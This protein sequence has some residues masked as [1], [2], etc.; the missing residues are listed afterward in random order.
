M[1]RDRG[2]RRERIEYQ[3][4]LAA[5]SREILDAAIAR[6]EPFTERLST[7]SVEEALKEIGYPLWFRS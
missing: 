2:T 1:R 5:R 7:W 6:G 4:R 3:D